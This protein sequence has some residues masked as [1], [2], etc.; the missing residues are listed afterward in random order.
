M[1]AAIDKVIAEQGRIDVLVHNAGHMTTGP[2]EAFSV[3]QF[4]SL[5]DVNVLSTQRVNRAARPG[6]KGS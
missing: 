5:Y 2:A 4:A 6:M 1:Q 3:G